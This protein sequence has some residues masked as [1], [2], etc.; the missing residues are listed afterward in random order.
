[1]FVDVKCELLC[2]GNLFEVDDEVL[3]GFGGCGGVEVMLL[4]CI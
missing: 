1:M 2:L 3:S 4:I